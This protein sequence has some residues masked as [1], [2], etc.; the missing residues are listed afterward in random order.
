MPVS[1]WCHSHFHPL[2][3]GSLNSGWEKQHYT[4]DADSEHIQSSADS[5][6]SP[7]RYCHLAGTVTKSSKGQST[8]LSSQLSQ[9]GEE[10]GNTSEFH[11]HVPIAALAV[12]WVP[13][14][15]AM[16]CGI[17]RQWIRHSVS[18]QIV[19]L[20]EA[21]DAEKA[22][23]HARLVSISVR[24]KHYPFHNRCFVQCNQCAIR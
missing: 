1:E 23:P 8:I 13:R 19:V 5:C 24:T 17:P 21:L 7:A 4:L 20:A 18:P 3:L 11:E 2:V 12:K 16:M 10:H 6:P 9:D 22:N 15:E 14:L